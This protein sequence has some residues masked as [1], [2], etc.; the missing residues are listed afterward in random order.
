MASVLPAVLAPAASDPQLHCLWQGYGEGLTNTPLAERCGCARGTVS[1]KLRPEQH[2]NHHR[3]P[4]V[5]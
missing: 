3:P 5:L 1:K 2:A 4:G